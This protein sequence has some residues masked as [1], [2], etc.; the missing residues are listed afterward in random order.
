MHTQITYCA[1]LRVLSEIP[2]SVFILQQRTLELREFRFK[3]AKPL[4]S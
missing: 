4:L 3:L 2:T 1:I